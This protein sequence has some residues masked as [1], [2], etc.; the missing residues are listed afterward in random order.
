MIHAIELENFKAFGNRVRLDFAPIT[1]IYGENSAGKSSIL[2]ALNLLKQTRFSREHGALLLPRAEGGLVDL[3]S[4]HELLYD[5]DAE[6]TLSLRLDLRGSSR[7]LRTRDEGETGRAIGLEVSFRQKGAGDVA[8]AG[9]RVFDGQR[10]ESVAQFEPQDL[11]GAQLQHSRRFSPFGPYGMR[12]DRKGPGRPRGAVCTE[13]VA[14]DHYWEAEYSRTLQLR[15]EILESL[16]A[17]REEIARQHPDRQGRLFPDEEFTV[18]SVDAAIRFYNSEFSL[19]AYAAR[20]RSASH[21][22]VVAL[23][24]FIPFAVSPDAGGE[25]PERTAATYHR[26]SRLPLRTHFIEAADTLMEAGVSLEMALE[27]LFPLGPYRKAPQRLYIFTGTTPP[28]VG[29]SGNLL[30]DLLFRRPKLVEETN[31][32]LTRLDVG[33]RIAIEP[34]GSRSNDLFEVRLQDKK[35]SAATSVA[36]P[37]V[38]FGI[39]QLLPFVVQVLAS[40]EQTITIEQPEVHV[41]PRLQADI[42]DLL[43]AGIQP[44]KAH[45]FIVE[46]HSEHLILRLLRRIRETAG[47]ELPEGHPGLRP[48]QLAVVYL[49]RGLGGTIVHQLRVDDQGEFIDQWPKGFFEERSREL[50]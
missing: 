6:R 16:A 14:D 32:W 39:S 38:G 5:H 7:M 27:R 18:E 4:F 26:R 2:N 21:G 37:D 23:D 8:L 25:Y 20:R 44:G 31:D 22:G 42:A 35:R 50:F 29:Y 34:V 11:H 30:P 43:V 48:A 46:T 41:H 1:L 45:R 15:T 28:D 33:Y 36:L 49:E 10:L 19:A 12:R 40:D 13:V 17:M 3:G 24:G 47:G 9:F